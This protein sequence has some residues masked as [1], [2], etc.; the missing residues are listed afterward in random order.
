MPCTLRFTTAGSALDIGSRQCAEFI[1]EWMR[2]PVF[3]DASLISAAWSG[4][5]T[6]CIS[7]AS[8]PAARAIANRS[9]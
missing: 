1:T 4:A 7:I 3:C 6:V 2:S 9:A 5:V 8:K